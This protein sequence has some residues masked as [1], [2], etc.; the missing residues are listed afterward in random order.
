MSGSNNHFGWKSEFS[1]ELIEFT[2]PDIMVKLI[3][4]IDSRGWPHITMI[5]SNRAISKD[6]IVWGQFFAGTSKENVQKN[7]KQGIFYM[8]AE[9]PFKFIQVKADF[10]HTKTEGEDLEYF[11]QTDLMRYFTV[12]NVYKVFYNKVIAVTPIRDLPPGGIPKKIIRAIIK[13]SKT[14]LE[15]KRLNVIGYKLFTDP[16]G[17]R[18]IAYINP[19]DGYPIIIP[20]LQLNAIDHSRLFFPLI[21]LKD[22]LLE[23]PVNSKVAVI[24]ANFD[25][26][27]QVVKGT[28]TGFQKLEN[29]EYGLIDI[30]EI[31]NSSPP[32]TGQIYPKIETRPKVNKFTL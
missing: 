5:T 6:Q 26:A 2:K 1:E 10:T 14:N 16:I 7:P 28:F 8:N 22:D 24:G 18:A 25:M 9:P 12:V 27:S 19:S 13:E 15:E 4:T 20:N 32:I 23:I 30:E 17:V 21:A 31:Y 11:N 3:S 29:I